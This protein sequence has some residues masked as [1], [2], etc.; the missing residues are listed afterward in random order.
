MLLCRLT[1]LMLAALP[2]TH[3]CVT[4][5]IACSPATLRTAPAPA[6]AASCP[7]SSAASSGGHPLWAAHPTQVRL[8][9]ASAWL[10]ALAPARR[11]LGWESC[12]TTTRTFPPAT[13]AARHTPAIPTFALPLHTDCDYSRPI[14]A[15][16]TLGGEQDAQ[17]PGAD[18][19]SSSDGEEDEDSESK[20]LA[21]EHNFK[22]ECW[23]GCA[24]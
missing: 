16:W 1:C 4:H 3:A 11:L 7:S 18:G 15:P 19:S 6:A 21:R 20:R 17:Q 24:A 22:G 9:A 8:A 5:C 13:A 2:I 23:G 14:S 12:R 10:P